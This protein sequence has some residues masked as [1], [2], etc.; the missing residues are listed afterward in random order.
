VIKKNILQV[1]SD[2]EMDRK[3]FLKY[4]GLVLISLVGLKTIVSILTQP[5]N[6]LT[7]VE[8]AKVTKS[9]F[10]SGKYGV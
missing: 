2:K 8:P 4:S 1:L 3:E 7:I 9:G 5:D 6:K 10:G